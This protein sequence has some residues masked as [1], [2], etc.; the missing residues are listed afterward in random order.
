[1]FFYVAYTNMNSV[2]LRYAT[3]YSQSM[4][5]RIKYPISRLMVDTTQ[6]LFNRI[7]LITKYR[8][9]EIVVTRTALPDHGD[10]RRGRRNER[11]YLEAS[12]HKINYAGPS[13]ESSWSNWFILSG[14]KPNGNEFYYRRWYTRYDVVSMEFEYQR[15]DV[16]TYNKII[17][18]MTLHDGILFD[19]R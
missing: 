19:Q 14:S 3:Y 6:E 16:E 17:E 11:N 10:P 9:Q 18:E 8:V 7:P 12:G 13:N 5:I 4:K 2:E 15:E 1:M